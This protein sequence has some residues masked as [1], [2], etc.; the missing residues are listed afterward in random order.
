MNSVTISAT[1]CGPLRLQIS[2]HLAQKGR[3]HRMWKGHVFCDFLWTIDLVNGEPEIG[4]T[5][6]HMNVLCREW[7]VPLNLAKQFIA[8]CCVAQVPSIEMCEQV[9]CMPIERVKLYVE[10]T[11]V[12][13]SN[14]TLQRCSESG[15]SVRV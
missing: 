8:H 3:I 10:K 9:L 11:C 13:R 2:V 14:L 7:R 5:I 15:L 1:A 4:V 12:Y 6:L